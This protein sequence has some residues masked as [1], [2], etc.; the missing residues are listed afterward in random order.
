[1]KRFWNQAQAEAGAAGWQVLLDGRAV[2]LPSGQPLVTPNAALARAIAAEWQQAG[3]AKD[4]P[5]KPDDVP[6]TR[7]FG[8]GLERI[9]PNPSSAR[10]TLARYGETD[11]LCYRAADRRL[12][13]RQAEAW[14]PWLGWAARSL[15]AALIVAPGLMPVAQPAAALQA[16]AARLAR[17]EALELAALG[18]AVPALGSLVLGLALAE[19]VLPAEE[20]HRLAMLEEAFQVE[21]WG[22]DAEATARQAGLAIDIALAARFLDLTRA[23]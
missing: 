16:L 12:K 8:T 2:R 7:L 1:V 20:A 21:Q 3:G 15:D 11:L 18:V 9:A 19:G 17:A 14:D 22:E 5:F 13:A 6:L 4:H 23:G 10:T